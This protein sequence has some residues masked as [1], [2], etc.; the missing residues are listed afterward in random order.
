MAKFDIETA[1]A[2]RVIGSKD[3]ERSKR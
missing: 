1:G 3:P 2:A